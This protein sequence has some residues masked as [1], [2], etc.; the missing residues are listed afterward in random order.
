[1]MI[2]YCTVADNFACT[3][4]FNG[5]KELHNWTRCVNNLECK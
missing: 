2:M 5:H 3:P 4:S 1:M